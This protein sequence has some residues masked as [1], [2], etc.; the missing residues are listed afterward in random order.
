MIDESSTPKDFLPALKSSYLANSPFF[1]YIRGSEF[2]RLLG[3]VTNLVEREQIKTLAILSAYPQE[4]RTFVVAT[5]ALGY[6]VLLKKRV[7]IVNTA[8]KLRANSLNI[9]RLYDEELRHAPGPK[10]GQSDRMID[11]MSPEMNSR[12]ESQ[13]DTVDFQIGNYISAFKQNYDLTLIDNCALILKD[14]KI[15][16]PIVIASQADASFLVTSEKSLKRGQLTETKDL[17]S[18]WRVRL[19]GSVYNDYSRRGILKP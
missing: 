10:R 9:K 6:A 8:L 19:V 12:E 11:L 1:S 18:K 17:L 14:E 15:I 2:K 4:G 16:D 13:A 3:Q 5:L 7:L